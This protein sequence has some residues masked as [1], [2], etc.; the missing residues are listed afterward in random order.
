MGTDLYQIGNH[1][2]NFS[3]KSFDDLTK[4]IKIKL[5]NT[6]F[7]NA[8]FLRLFA[9]RWANSEPRRVRQIREIKTKKDWTF[10][11]EDEYYNFKE[12][13]TIDFYGPFDLELTFD[14]QKILFWNPP[15]RYWYWFEME[16]E[17]HR[18]EWRKYMLQIL[19]LFGGDRVI[20]LAD[21]AHHLDEFREF[22]GTFDEIESALF[23]K[24]GKPKETFKEVASDFDNSYFIDI[25]ETINWESNEPLNEYLPEPDDT[26]STDFDLEKYSSKNEIKELYFEN[27]FLMHKIIGNSIH[28]YHLTVIKGLLCIHFG[29]V[30]GTEKIE[31]KLDKHAPFVFDEIKMELMQKGYDNTNYKDYTIKFNG[32]KNVESWADAINEFETELIWSGNGAMSGSSSNSKGKV[33]KWFYAVNENLALELLLKLGKKFNSNGKIQVYKNDDK[34]MTIIYQQ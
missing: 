13:K 18:D 1:K 4:E 2:I 12:D 5:D 20:Y 19:K 17:V 11:E 23:K 31:V 10:R 6:I 34:K 22:E 14:E 30:G 25:F 15:Y 21:N 32:W 16:D 29:Q 24:Y 3:K 27:E 28:F 33:E 9:L 26:S 8:D 7:P